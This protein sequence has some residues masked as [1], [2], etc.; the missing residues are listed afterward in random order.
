MCL[1]TDNLTTGITRSPERGSAML[2][3]MVVVSALLSGA[4]VL[5]SIQTTSMRASTLTS[6]GITMSNCAEAGLVAARPVVFANYTQWAGSIG[7]NIEPL[8]LASAFSHD[9]DG[10]GAADFVITLADDDDELLPLSNDRTVDR[11]SRIYVVSQCIKNPELPKQVSE[12]VQYTGGGTCYQS[13][14]GGCDG[15]GNS[16]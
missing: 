11:N 3:T 10:D 1:T 5:A 2:V 16:N 9:L 6:N 8:W 7:T 14:I 12:L 15:N 13:Q 4:A